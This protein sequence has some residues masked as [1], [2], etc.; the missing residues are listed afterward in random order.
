MSFGNAS[1]QAT[2][3]VSA[4]CALTFVLGSI[5]AFSIFIPSWEA[6]T[7]ASRGNVSLIYSF[8][9]LSLTVTVLIGYRLYDRLPPSTLFACSGLVA[10][11]GLI[12][13]SYSSS[14]LELY[15]YYGLIFGTAN[16]LGYGFALQLAGQ[17]MPNQ[18]GFAMSLVTAFYAVGATGSPPLF[19]YLL[20]LRDLHFTLLIAAIVVG[21]VSLLAAILLNL[22]RADYQSESPENRI[23][24]N[25]TQH[26]TRWLLWLSYGTAVTAGLM[27]IG[28][29]YNIAIWKE[30]DVAGATWSTMLVAAGNMLG[31]FSAGLLVLR[32]SNL[33]LIRLLPLL[34]LAGLIAIILTTSTTATIIGLTLVGFS[35]GAIIAIY[36][37]SV[38]E[39]FGALAAPRIYGQIF[40]AWGL[41]G[42]FGPWISGVLFDKYHSYQLALVIAAILSVVS[43]LLLLKLNPTQRQVH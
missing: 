13:S 33:G 32:Y 28:H 8:A 24:L 14:L 17:A 20:R 37:S 25:A 21:T 9:L 40:T 42:L 29:A 23:S 1:S 22:T 31:G 4:C 39:L 30:S 10:A 12:A 6:L 35:Y 27:V 26:R 2:L 11:S 3:T 5:H 19:I 43:T 41:A 7:G 34:G 18:R 16:G 36:P 38:S 15:I